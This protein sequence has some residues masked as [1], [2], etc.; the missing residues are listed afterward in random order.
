MQLPTARHI[1][2]LIGAPC[3]VQRDRAGRALFVSDYPRRLPT[4]EADTAASQLIAAGYALN[5]LP[6]GLALIDWTDER[7]RK[8]YATLPEQPLPAMPEGREAAL[9]GI[10]RLLMQHPAPLDAQDII[11]LR[12][13]IGVL[14]P[15]DRGRLTDLLATALA[16]ALREHRAPPYHA[17]RLLVA[18]GIIGQQEV[19]LESKT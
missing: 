10:C 8:F 5:T 12:R 4:Q 18:H 6:D 15:A 19:T 11:V 3:L 13:T 14:A 17:A 9:W 2:Q 7:C 16:D 1:K